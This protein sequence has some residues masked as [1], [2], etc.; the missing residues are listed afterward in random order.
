MLVEVFGREP[1]MKDMTGQ[2]AAYQCAVLNYRPPIPE[3]TP[4]HVRPL[5]M[6]CWAPDPA[7]R[8]SFVE[9]IQHLRSESGA[10][11]IALP[12]SPSKVDRKLATNDPDTEP[13]TWLRAAKVLMNHLA[14]RPPLWKLVDQGIVKVDNAEYWFLGRKGPVPI[15]VVRDPPRLY[16]QVSDEKLREGPA[17]L[18]PDSLAYD[19]MPAS[20]FEPSNKTNKNY[21]FEDTYSLDSEDF[22]SNVNATL[23]KTSKNDDYEDTYSLADGDDFRNNATAPEATVP[24]ESPS[25]THL[26]RKSRGLSDASLKDTYLEEQTW[27]EMS[28]PVLDDFVGSTTKSRMKAPTTNTKAKS[29]PNTNTRTKTPTTK[30]PTT[31]SRQQPGFDPMLKYEMALNR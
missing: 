4:E 29:K 23:L 15:E 14:N 3:A 12:L 11:N 22:S 19:S 27:Q 2:R 30:A 31:K 1:P 10:A 18:G 6:S 16:H 5:V 9:I 7:H 24:E 8:P 26:T 20:A 13:L 21:D 25:P 28:E 17:A